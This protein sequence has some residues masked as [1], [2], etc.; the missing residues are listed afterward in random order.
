MSQRDTWPLT[1]VGTESISCKHGASL[2]AGVLLKALYPVCLT[3]ALQKPHELIPF[4]R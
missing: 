3:E 4:H 1:G 2:P